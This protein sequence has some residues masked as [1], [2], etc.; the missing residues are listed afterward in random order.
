VVIPY[1]LEFWVRKLIWQVEKAIPYSGYNIP[2]DLLYCTGKKTNKR[3]DM[4]R[5]RSDHIPQP[6]VIHHA[7]MCGAPAAGHSKVVLAHGCAE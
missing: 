4:K 2:Y 7:Y 5:M 3:K 1:D 6:I